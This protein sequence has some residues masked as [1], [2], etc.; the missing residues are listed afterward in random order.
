MAGEP[1]DAYRPQPPS[2]ELAFPSW[3]NLSSDGRVT[4]LRTCF[5]NKT[6][7]PLVREPYTE[8]DSGWLHLDF[9]EKGFQQEA[10]LIERM[11][12]LRRKLIPG[13]ETEAR[14]EM[15]QNLELFAQQFKIH[16][17]PKSDF[18]PFVFERLVKFFQDNPEARDLVS[19]F[20]IRYKDGN[21]S[22]KEIVP[23]IVIYPNLGKEN[24][25]KVLGQLQEYFKE[26]DSL[27]SGEV[28]RFNKQ[29]SPLLFIAQFDGKTKG[30]LREVG[31]LDEYFDKDTNY[32]FLKEG[33]AHI[34]EPSSQ[35]RLDWNR[36]FL[37]MA[38]H[39]DKIPVTNIRWTV[40]E[41][42]IIKIIRDRLQRGETIE[43]I[44]K[45]AAANVRAMFEKVAKST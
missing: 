11:V 44:T 13:N 38:M 14:A 24:A 23:Q 5:R 31:L 28:P 4:F 29:I 43:E 37:N 26:L 10:L 27:G 3:N 39:W 41:F 21:Q 17:Q 40:Q 1:V 15:N 22:S 19:K 33:K 6:A 45:K 32:G 16:L 7:F 8:N 34:E 35:E 20:K 2:G 30:L 42:E 9:S 25:Q 18:I 12:A 36:K